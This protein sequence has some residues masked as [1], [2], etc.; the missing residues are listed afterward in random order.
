LLVCVGQDD[1]KTKGPTELQIISPE[2]K[3]LKQVPLKMNPQAIC[4]DNQGNIYVV[5]SDRD[6]MDEG[7]L[8]RC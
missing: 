2:G 5:V 3:V 1:E 6:P 8:R 7:D 4:T